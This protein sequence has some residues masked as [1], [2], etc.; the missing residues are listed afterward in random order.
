MFR[1]RRDWREI[2]LDAKVHHNRL[3]EEEEVCIS[4]PL[5]QMETIG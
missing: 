2:V 4:Q 3:Q 5:H 1:D